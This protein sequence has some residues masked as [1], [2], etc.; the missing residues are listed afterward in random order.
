[1]SLVGA[2]ARKRHEAS[3]AARRGGRD[4]HG[5]RR[6]VLGPH[7]LSRALDRGADPGAARSARAALVGRCAA[8]AFGW[9]A[10]AHRRPARISRTSRRRAAHHAAARH[11][12][13]LRGQRDGRSRR[14]ARD[15]RSRSSSPGGHAGSMIVA[16]RFHLTYCSNI[17]AGESWSDV[18][19]ALGTA[20]PRV[21]E[22]LGVTGPFAVGLRL[23]AE[24]AATLSGAAAQAEFAAFLR[25]GRYYLLTINGFPYGAFHGMRVKERVY[26]PDWRTAARLEYTN[27]LATLLAAL[28]GDGLGIERSVSTVPGAFRSEVRG[29]ADAAAIAD[30]MLRHAA[31]LIAIR[32]STGTYVSLAV[33]PEPACFIETIADAEAFFGRYLFEAGRVAAIARETGVPMTVDAVRS[34]VGLCFDACHMAVEFEDASAAFDRLRGA[35]IRVGKVQI[36]SALQC[37]DCEPESIACALRPFADDTYLHQVVERADG[38]L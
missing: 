32:Q 14:A 35:G 21:R 5:A 9:R 37:D 18:R 30:N 15:R 28:A 38:Q 29:E 25:D 27:R 7:G 1:R 4:R 6:H 11:R 22:Q 23:S 34:H 13:K 31:H 17:H 36:S 8:R 10:L 12:R 16:D 2:Q 26:L 3:T 33:E 20:L 19:A 24:A